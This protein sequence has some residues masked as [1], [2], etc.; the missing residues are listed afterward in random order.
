MT[1]NRLRAGFW[2]KPKAFGYGATP[3]TWQGWLVVVLF[4]LLVGVILHLAMPRHPLFLALL[5]PLA[6]GL[7]WISWAKTDGDWRWRS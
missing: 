1:D 3:A 5:A 6:L 4:V 2:F 7:V